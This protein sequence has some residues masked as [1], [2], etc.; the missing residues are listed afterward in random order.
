MLTSPS[1]RA[2]NTCQLAGLGAAAATE[3][4]LAEWH[5]GDY[6]GV[7]SADI[8]KTRPDWNIWRDGCPHGEMPLQVSDRANRI[9]ARL[10]KLDGNVALFSHGQFGAALAARWIGLPLAAG[11]HFALETASISVLG[12]Q[13]GHPDVP[14]IARW[15]DSQLLS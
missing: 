4:D 5:Y 10:R 3:P 13:T 6:E 15:N 8:R 11:G 2:Q 7:R 12:Y 1:Q 9:I 14:V